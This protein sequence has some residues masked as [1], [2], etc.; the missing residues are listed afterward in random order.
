MNAQETVMRDAPEAMIESYTRFLGDA[1]S[2]VA[3][4]HE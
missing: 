1:E 2:H 3:Q 4:E